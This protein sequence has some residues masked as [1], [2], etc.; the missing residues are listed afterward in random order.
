MEAFEFHPTG[1]AAK[2]ATHDSLAVERSVAIGI[3]ARRIGLFVDQSE[4]VRQGW[5]SARSMAALGSLLAAGGLAF[6]E[7]S[8]VARRSVCVGK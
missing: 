7:S 1:V 6:L 2:V 4:M 8:F 3:L 5:N